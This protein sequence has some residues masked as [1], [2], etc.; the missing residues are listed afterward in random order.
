MWRGVLHPPPRSHTIYTLTDDKCI[1]LFFTNYFFIIV[2][3]PLSILSVKD[4]PW[5]FLNIRVFTLYVYYT[6]TMPRFVRAKT[7][8][9]GIILCIREGRG[10]YCL[11]Y[12]MCFKRHKMGMKLNILQDCPCRF[13]A[14]PIRA[15]NAGLVT[16]ET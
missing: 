10:I 12:H 3:W 14:I 5:S 2:L 6:G 9:F 15:K 11:L 16:L 4:A 1:I 7:C 13:H 8:F